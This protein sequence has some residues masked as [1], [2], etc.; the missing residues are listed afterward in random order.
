MTE[1]GNAIASETD[2]A[3]LLELIAK[4]LRELIGARLVFIALPAGE[5]HSSSS[6]RATMTDGSKGLGVELSR[7]ESKSG[8]VLERRRPERVDSL[9]DDVEFDRAPCGLLRAERVAGRRPPASSYR[10]SSE[11]E[12]IGVISIHDKPAPTSTICAS[13]TRTCA[14]AEW[15]A[16]RAA[17]AV[18]LSATG[19][20]RRPAPG[21]CRAGARAQAPR[22]RA[23]R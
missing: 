21:R 13:P 20:A 16:Q 23:P 4:R 8:R 17:V 2:L 22:T 18:D 9:I 14:L 5:R 11:D 3:A 1:V 6:T 12:A 7:S 19:A 15:F 10:C